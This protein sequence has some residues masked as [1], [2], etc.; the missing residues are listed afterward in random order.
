VL[1]AD[2]QAVLLDSFDDLDM[3]DF[4]HGDLRLVNS[5]SSAAAI[6]GSL[7]DKVESTTDLSPW[8]SRVRPADDLEQAL[9]GRASL[10]DGESLI[11][12][13]GYWISR[14]FLR[15]RRAGEAESGLLA[16]G[17]ELERL[18]SERNEHEASLELLSERL[19]QLR[20]A[21]R[22]QEARREQQRR[23]HQD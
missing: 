11:S 21:Q 4:E 14:Q 10:G 3:T 13:D 19:A 9:A 6:N 18:Q 20:E 15:V 17:Q 8:L 5:A 23:E 2:L 12:R 22:E 7:L 16:R 1:G